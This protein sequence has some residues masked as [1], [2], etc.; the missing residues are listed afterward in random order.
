MEYE[1]GE[2]A[3]GT[4]R[5]PRNQ[6]ILTGKRLQ[7]SYG[8]TYH[9]DNGTITTCQCENPQ[10]ADWS[11]S[12]KNIDV[13]LRGKGEISD[14]FF[15]VRGV[16]LFYIPYGVMSVRTER[17]SGLLFPYYG[18]SNTRGFVWQQPFY[19]AINKSYDLTLT[20]DVETAAR[21]GL[22]GDF[23]YAPSM[24]TEGEFSASY[25]NQ[26]IG[27]PATTTSPINRWSITGT[28][29]QSLADD[30]R[31]YSDLFFVSDDN[32][33]REISHRALNLPAFEEYADWTVRSRRYT[34]SHVGE[35]KTWPNALLRAEAS[36]YQDL[37]ESQDYAFQVLPRLQFQGQ[38][39]FWQDRLETGVAVEEAYFYRNA[40]YAGQRLDLAPSL[41]MPFHLSNY[42][43]GS[44]RV[45][46]R[47]TGYIMT[48]NEQGQP[49]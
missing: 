36:Y 44:F 32:F 35:V 11:V 28:H 33:L 42:A 12:A 13:T 29:R 17:Q 20:T 41:T 26:Q 37:L 18:F 2:I 8:Q 48:S 16:P 7:K 43:Y 46:G 40:G 14:A 34:D 49:P 21:L 38:R 6:Y 24:Q 25:F 31:F 15:R 3:N 19:W 45:L 4:V 27:G 5:L 30:L 22:W 47:E 9:I 10:K 23:R 39:R 1:T